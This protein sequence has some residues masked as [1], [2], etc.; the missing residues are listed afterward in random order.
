LTTEK[1][2]PQAEYTTLRGEF[3]Q[4]RKYVFE[5]PLLIVGVGIT[6]MT[7]KTEPVTAVVLPALMTGLLLFNF[8]FTV[9]RLISSARVVAYILL[10]LE[11]GAPLP[12]AGWETSLRKYRV[13]R[14]TTPN[15]QGIIDERM[16]DRD[17]PDSLMYYGPIF[18]L[19]GA[20]VVF[21][22]IIAVRFTYE[23]PKPVNII[24]VCVT[25]IAVVAFTIYAIRW[26]PSRMQTMIER[27]VIIW[28]L[29]LGGTS[30]PSNHGLDRAP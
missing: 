16:K 7:T 29:V 20:L 13:W 21:S 4:S 6:L 8:W 23:D 11:P 10:V 30:V 2:T 22:A 3:D 27:N 26:P 14:T 1:L 28:G 18:W 24:A 9:N 5:R 19:H 15:A 17:V 12:W 25:M